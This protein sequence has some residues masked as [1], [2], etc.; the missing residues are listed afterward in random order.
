MNLP[1]VASIRKKTGF[2]Q[3]RFATLLGVS[4]C[5]GLWNHDAD[6]NPFGV[7]GQTTGFA[8][9]RR[10]TQGSGVPQPWADRCNPFGVEATCLGLM[11]PEGYI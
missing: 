5:D 10:C 6:R 2:S 4:K 1:G 8:L 9:W 7:V 3:E 11:K